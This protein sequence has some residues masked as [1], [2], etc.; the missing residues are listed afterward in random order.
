MKFQNQTQ[1]AET[2]TNLGEPGRHAAGEAVDGGLGEARPGEVEVSEGGG[3]PPQQLP[4]PEAVAEAGAHGQVQRV[5]G[6]AAVGRVA[7]PPPHAE[8][9]EAR[10]RHLALGNVIS[11]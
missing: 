2:N 11:A 7:A 5:E 10:P 1:R 6:G 8:P 4:Q 9:L 3:R